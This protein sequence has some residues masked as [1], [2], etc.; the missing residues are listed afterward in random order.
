MAKRLRWGEGNPS[1]KKIA[2]SKVLRNFFAKRSKETGDAGFHAFAVLQQKVL[3]HAKVYRGCENQY[4]QSNIQTPQGV[5][6]Y[7]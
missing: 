5:K 4:F 2:N 6:N 1:L 7:F 3:N